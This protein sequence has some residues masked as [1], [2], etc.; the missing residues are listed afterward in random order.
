MNEWINVEEVA[1]HE[2]GQGMK[3]GG[4]CLIIGELMIFSSPVKQ[5]PPFWVGSSRAVNQEAVTMH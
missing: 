1:G 3:K 5:V 2:K 4:T